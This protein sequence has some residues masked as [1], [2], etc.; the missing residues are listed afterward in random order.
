VNH[1]ELGLNTRAA[2]IRSELRRAGYGGVSRGDFLSTFVLIS[3][4]L[5]QAQAEQCA[6]LD[7][8]ISLLAEDDVT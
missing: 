3:Q 8:Q 4:N 2:A 1:L 6:E 5:M 7:L